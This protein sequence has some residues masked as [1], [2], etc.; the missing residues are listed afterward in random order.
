[1]TAFVTLAI[2]FVICAAL[3]ISIIQFQ[4]RIIEAKNQSKNFSLISL[5]QS[6]AMQ[7]ELVNSV[8]RVQ[9]SE[10]LIA[11]YEAFNNLYFSQLSQFVSLLCASRDKA[12]ERLRC[13]TGISGALQSGTATPKYLYEVIARYAGYRI[14]QFPTDIKPIV[15]AAAKLADERVAFTRDKGL[16]ITKVKT[17]CAVIERYFVLS[18]ESNSDSVKLASMS[19]GS[20][21]DQSRSIIDSMARD[22]VVAARLRCYSNFNVGSA[23]V[24][25][26]IEAS[27]VSQIA[28]AGNHAAGGGAM[29]PQ[30]GQQ[31]GDAQN[32][33]GSKSEGLGTVGEPTPPPNQNSGKLQADLSNALFFDLISYYRFYE[34]ILGPTITGLSVIAPIDITFILLVILCGALGA[35]LRIAAESY[36]PRLFGKDHEPPRSKAVYSFVLG[37]MCALIVYILAKTVYSGLGESTYTTKSGNLSPFVTAFLAIVSGLICEEAF[38]QIIVAGKAML[39]RSTGGHTNGGNGGDGG[40]GHTTQQ[41]S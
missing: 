27:T 36:D 34:K 32:M 21:D 25:M 30:H 35:M 11:S 13:A 4:I 14:D 18:G 22:Y 2:G 16:A 10:D 33:S 39:A 9:S 5:S 23:A 26:P 19:R 28:G 40:K 24:I 8:E 31:S 29:P 12:D 41:P 3:F 20:A 6:V 15:E 17:S 1:M 37:I 7:K 38:Q